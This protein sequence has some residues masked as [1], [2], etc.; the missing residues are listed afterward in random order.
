MNTFH[1]FEVPSQLRVAKMRLG[2]LAS[3]CQTV[4]PQVTSREPLNGLSRNLIF[5]SFTKICLH[6]QILV[7]IGQE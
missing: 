3:S 7:K 6:I 2:L 5:V 1:S 4:R